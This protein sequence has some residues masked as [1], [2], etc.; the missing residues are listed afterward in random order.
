MANL[1]QQTDFETL[2]LRKST[3]EYLKNFATINKSIVI[4]AGRVLSTMSVSK[5]IISVCGMNDVFPA[6]MAI[7]DLP[8]F[9]GALSLFD[10]PVLG[11]VDDKKVLIFDE[12]TKAKT[13]YYYSDPEMIVT[14]PK[15]FNLDLP[16]VDFNFDLPADDLAKL[17]KAAAVYGVEDICITGYKG[18]YSICVKDRKNQSSNVFSLPLQNVALNTANSNVVLSEDEI[19]YCLKVDNLKIIPGSYHVT[20]STRNASCWM[21]TGHSHLSYYIALEPN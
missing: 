5:S 1:S 15:E 19:C 12:K 4:R 3:I 11:F 20:I 7:Y 8:L 18:E 10:D 21:A 17:L 2:K 16:D 9:L 14:V 13:T 6:D